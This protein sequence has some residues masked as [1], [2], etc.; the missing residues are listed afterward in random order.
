MWEMYRTAVEGKI[1]EGK[2]Q[3]R[4]GRI[5]GE[6]EKGVKGSEELLQ[7][8]EL[9]QWKII[10]LSVQVKYLLFLFSTANDY[11]ADCQALL[12]K[13]PSLVSPASFRRR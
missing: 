4:V 10:Y 7:R 9:S 6:M 8:V 2:L 12:S 3:E 1:K 13:Y 5:G 11:Y